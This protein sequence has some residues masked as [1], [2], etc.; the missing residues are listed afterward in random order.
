MQVKQQMIESIKGS[1]K[2]NQSITKQ[3]PDIRNK[4]K[5]LSLQK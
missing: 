1:A 2:T 4:I 3:S 5:Q